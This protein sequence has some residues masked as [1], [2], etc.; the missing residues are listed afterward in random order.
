MDT[1]DNTYHIPVM[2]KEV[3]DALEPK[4]GGIYFDGTLGG[5]GHSA[6]IMDAGASLIATDRDDSALEFA[7]KRFEAEKRYNELYRLVKSDFKDY[8]AV[9][10]GAKIDKVDGVVLDL[11]VSSYQIDTVETGFSYR[12][13]GPL[14][15]R[16][17][18]SGGRTAYDVINGYSE[19]ELVKIFF[20][21]G[22][23]RFSR[24]IA[25]KIINSRKVS[26]IKST[27]EL[28]ELIKSCVPYNFKD[29]H[30]AK[31][32]FQAVRIEVNGELDRLS[33]AIEGLI[34]RLKIGGR[35]VVIS[36]HSL[37]DRITKNILRKLATDCLCDKSLPICVCGHKASVKLLGKYKAGNEEL[38]RNSRA[39]SATLRIAEKVSTNL[40]RG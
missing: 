27:L 14:D 19:K 18:R 15:M 6:G 12:I 10:D 24:K 23:E 35:I 36:F 32:V 40:R 22:E 28:A 1:S 13:D 4:A 20:E 5:G 38:E 34:G 29:G 11:G 16:M 25:A 26:P 9:L 37:E 3:L 30:P 33:E 21:Y 7:G 39:K 17:D 2:L 8:S 31:R